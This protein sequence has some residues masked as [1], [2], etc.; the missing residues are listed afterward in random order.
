MSYDIDAMR[1]KVRTQMSGKRNDPDEFK[2]AKAET[3]KELKYR[4][5]IL[6]PYGENDPLRTGPASHSMDTFFIPYG[7]HFGVCRPPQPCPR[8]CNGEPCEICQHGFDLMKEAGEDRDAKRVIS[9]DWM[10]ATYHVVNVYF[11]VGNGNP[12]DLEGRVM[13][14]K[15]PKTCFDIWV[16]ALERTGPGDKLDPQA[17]GAFFDEN[18][19]FLFQLSCKYKGQNN[20]YES[21]GFLSNGGAPMAISDQAGIQ[22]IMAAR[23]DLSTKLEQPNLT[24]LHS[25]AQN[26]IHGVAQDDGFSTPVTA[27]APV[28]ATAPVQ[29]VAPV[30]PAPVQPVAPV[31]PVVPVQPVMAAPVAPTPDPV[32]AAQAALAAA[33]AQVAAA[34]QAAA[35]AQVAATPVQQVAPAPVAPAPVAPAAA[36]VETV[37]PPAGGG[38]GDD[39][40]NE[41]ESMLEGFKN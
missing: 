40:M 15:A 35:Q 13:Y 16:A 20:T 32:A 19:A 3:G 9:S 33:Q 18:A 8:V 28:A 12:S 21:S 6:P 30:A 5:F 41:I 29:P 39:V 10:A 17:Y 22:Q 24:T 27:A 23:F 38:G 4:F 1:K 7:I 34:A 11:P 36:V 26:L 31:A 14:Y 25:V 37:Q 2:P